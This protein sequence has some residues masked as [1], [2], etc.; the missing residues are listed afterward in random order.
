MSLVTVSRPKQYLEDTVPFPNIKSN[1]RY[2]RST[3]VRPVKDLKDSGVLLSKIQS[4]VRRFH[5]SNM[6]AVSK[7]PKE[8]G[9]GFKIQNILTVAL[10]KINRRTALLLIVSSRSRKRFFTCIYN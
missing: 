8:R 4:E 6:G 10:L 2:N 9:D 1:L 7:D 3:E 5:F